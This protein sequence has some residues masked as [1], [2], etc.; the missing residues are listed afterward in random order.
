MS[1][2]LAPIRFL[3]RIL[4]PGLG[5]AL[6]VLAVLLSGARLLLPI[7][8]DTA[9][10]WLERTARKAGVE[11]QAGALALD[12]HGLGPRLTLADTTLNGLE[13]HTPLHLQ[14]LAL[15]LD[16]PRSLLTARLQFASL[17]VEGANLQLV[18][19]TEGR[20]QLPG[21][22]T[23][24]PVAPAE[25]HWPAWLGLARHVHL[26]G[27]R[28]GLHDQRSGESVEIQDIE[29]LFEEGLNGLR[30]AL[31]LNL[32]P[33]LGGQLEM[34][35]RLE[36]G[37]ADALL[38]S[39]EVWLSSSGLDMV[40]WS[41]LLA[42]LVG[43]AELLPIA[44]EA[45]PRFEKGAVRG[46]AW[47]TLKEG[48]LTEAQTRLELSDWRLSPLQALRVGEREVALTTRLDMRLRHA[49]ASWQ[50]DLNATPSDPR[51]PAQRFS[52]RREQDRLALAGEQFDLDLLRPW[53]V[54]TPMLPET[55]QQALIR[56]RP[57]GRLA[58]LHLAVQLGDSV[59]PELKG[60]ARFE[61]LSWRGE[62]YL[63]DV[64]GVRGEAWLTGQA[65]L[66]RL[67]S[68][69]LT[70]DFHGKFREPMR[71]DQARADLALF[72]T[73]TPRL[74]SPTLQLA[75]RDL[76]L[77][78]R[79]QLDLPEEGAPLIALD[80]RFQRVRAERIPAYLPVEE[81]GH[82]ARVWLDRALP[83]SGGFVP[84]GTLRLYGDLDR[85]PYYDDGRGLFEV[86]F[87]FQDLRLDYAP[88][89][90][91]AERLH[92]E[93]AF[94]NN[95]LMGR[96]DGG[97]LR[98]LGLREGGLAIPDFDHPRLDLRLAF[99]GKVETM[100]EIL[101]D[102]PVIK[103]RAA[104][105]EVN[106]NG[107]A[108]LQ[109]A[110]EVRLD[111]ADPRPDQ[112]QGWLDLHG[113]RL[114]AYEQLFEAIDGR[115]M[116]HDDRL[117]AQDIRARYRGRE[118]RLAV[119]SEPRGEGYAYRLHLDIQTA[120]R[121][122]LEVGSP[123]A[124]RLPGVFPVQAALTLDP[125][126][127]RGRRFEL[128]LSSTLEGLKID[129]PAPLGKSAEEARP[130]RARLTWRAGRLERLWLEQAGWLS[131]LLELADGRV[132]RGQLVLGEGGP[133]TPPGEGRLLIEARLPVF[134]LGAWLP[135]LETPAEGDSSLPSKMDLRA[136]FDRLEALGESWEAMQVQGQ[137]DASGW[138]L[139]LESPRLAGLVR[140]PARPSPAEPLSV[141]LARL[142]FTDEEESPALPD[143]NAPPPVDPT[144]LP[145]LRISVA[146]LYRHGMRLKDVRLRTLPQPRGLLLQELHA[147][148]GHLTIRGEGS[149]M[150]DDKSRHQTSLTL[151]LT[152]DDVGTAL[153]E[154][155]FAKTLRKGRL[156]E[157]QLRLHWPDAPDRFAW[158]ILS[159]E[160]RLNVRDGVI[161]KVE[162]GAGR[163]LGLLSLSDLP[164][165]LLLD[166][167]DVFG[168]GLRFDRI[169]ATLSFRDGRAVTELLQLS[170][171]AAQVVMRGYSD[172]VQHTLHY[173]MVVVPALGNVLP[174]LG[175]VA[176]GPLVGGA[177]FLLQKVF[178]QLGGE[179]S[180][181]NYRVSGS[182]DEPKIE[183]VEK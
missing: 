94:I 76:A 124:Q 87:A 23:R 173:D 147:D 179:K 90:R 100:L 71:F 101:K 143:P 56:H 122:W 137:R 115:L 46:Q 175:T 163:V 69:G 95:G 44:R 172:M 80:G 54:V 82:E 25:P 97:S 129:L 63:P 98:G 31:R 104:L 49:G 15:S 8:D 171:P 162:P 120:A 126:A 47:L 42:Q 73:D 176:G 70:A 170:G 154:L 6:I 21:L 35:A 32:P 10:Q 152:S 22:D 38:P 169:A 24:T 181:F 51:Q 177:V 79:L 28:L 62:G 14:R 139:R 59:Q 125:K 1:R 148:T 105:D 93:L 4:L 99:A 107:P 86:R 30:L 13:G 12:W 133:L 180:G 116:I 131:A 174:V 166:F 37:L 60:H 130:T 140:L 33:A 39:G 151:N 45:L 20:W 53:L 135:I 109:L 102:S 118:A 19:D 178:D 146:E 41:A 117:E 132:R 110:V 114:L 68:P 18:R 2:A 85:F 7:F 150:L 161:E 106:L 121:D 88:G 149:W 91:P 17:E 134:D 165:R 48:T 103:D 57:S 158:A 96:I 144:T 58:T 78:A 108:S 164:R 142:I 84:E 92:G 145:P 119:A 123:W 43:D 167:G 160:A 40:G 111:S 156:E 3:Q 67:D 128:E 182:W 27:G 11:L 127:P 112:A 89:W 16:L 72:W 77:Q 136:R 65:A 36:G 26:M 55:L 64:A 74:V 159:G 138:R 141:D 81:I 157:T 168:E 75:N 153:G 113:A 52:L 83:Q 155:G 34:H 61:G 183:R 66:L 9:R 29:A 5:L 50:L